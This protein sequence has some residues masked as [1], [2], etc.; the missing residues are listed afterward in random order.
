MAASLPSWLFQLRNALQHLA[1]GAD[2]FLYG[3]RARGDF[4]PISDWD[5]L[6]LVHEE[7]RSPAHLRALHAAVLEVE[8][9]ESNCISL[10]V[11]SKKEWYNTQKITPFFKNI[12]QEGI[13]L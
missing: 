3:S 6:L 4:R 12:Q 2:L 9:Q 5:L 13:M 10:Q 7:H 11:F 8:L 1:A